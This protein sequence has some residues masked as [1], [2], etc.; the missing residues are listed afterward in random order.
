[1]ILRHD[2]GVTHAAFS[3]NGDRIVTASFDKTARIWN[4]E[5]GSEI[6]VLKGHQARARDSLFSPDGSRVAT[7][8]RDGTARIW[9]A[10]SGEQMF[11]LRSA[12]RRSHGNVQPRR[13]APAHRIEFEQSGRLGCANRGKSRDSRRATVRT[14]ATFSPDGRT[15]AACQGSERTCQIWSTKTASRSWRYSI[16]A[17]PHEI[18]FSP[19]GRRALDRVLGATF[20]PLGTLGC[21]ERCRDRC[22]SRSRERDARRRVQSRRPP[23]RHRLHRGHGTALGRRHRRVAK[24]ARRGKR[25]EVAPTSAWITGTRTEWRIQP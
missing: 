7:A 17:W 1:M 16:R 4:V 12:R 10:G 14:S 22:S 19:D 20:L 18:V 6:A 11:V 8:A 21:V 13:H 25:L 3:P 9:N 24:R 15:F 2:G 23:C 5:D